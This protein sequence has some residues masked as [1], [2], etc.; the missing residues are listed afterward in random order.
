[1]RILV[2][3]DAILDTRLTCV[4]TIDPDAAA[5]LVSSRDYY[6]RQNDDFS[7]I[8]NIE[9]SR[10]LA[11]YNQ[12][13]DIHVQGARITNIII[14]LRELTRHLRDLVRHEPIQDSLY[15]DLNIYPYDLKGSHQ[16][17]C[18]AVTAHCAPETIVNI[19]NYRPEE[20]HPGKLKKEYHAL[21]VYNFDAWFSANSAAF[22][23]VD[24]PRVTVF[25]PA[26]YRNKE[27]ELDEEDLGNLKTHDP[28]AL[29]E[30][31]YVF[32]MKLQFLDPKDFSILQYWELPEQPETKDNTQTTEA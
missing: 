6:F 8:T 29:L 19:V 18:A 13:S 17:V 28:F 30:E 5:N 3:L 15:V 9:H 23:T 7:A 10:Y 1:M 31:T 26:L 12:R 14:M 16:E 25:A 32:M 2:E 24:M 22:A 21:I 27:P 4:A 20:L 11:E